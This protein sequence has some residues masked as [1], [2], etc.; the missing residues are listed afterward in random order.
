MKLNKW[1]YSRRYNIKASFDRFPNST[2]LF[3]RIKDYYFVYN[4]YWSTHDPIVGR[5]DLEEMELLL[6]RDLGSEREYINRRSRG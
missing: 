4:V 6:N 3:R 1:S 5:R 2:V